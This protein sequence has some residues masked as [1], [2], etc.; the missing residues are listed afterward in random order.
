MTALPFRWN[1]NGRPRLGTLLEGEPASHYPGF[2]DDLR[3]CAAKIVASAPDGDLVFVGRSL[4]SIYDYLTGVLGATSWRGRLVLLI[5][6]MR[7]TS[8]EELAR[9][10]PEALRSGREHLAALGLSPERIERS[11]RPKV[12]VDLVHGGSTF[13]HLIG[14]LEHWA[15][16]S[17]VAVGALRRRVRFLG[18]TVRGKNSP[19]TWRWYQQVEWARRLPRSALRGISIPWHLWTYL[20][21]RQSKITRSHTPEHWGAEDA[22]LPPRRKEALEALRLA[23]RIHERGCERAERHGFAAALAARRPLRDPSLRRLI[24]ELRRG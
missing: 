17:G 10:N 3:D 15:E 11:A 22:S 1:L 14:L 20:G 19:N 9:T 18:I 13:G 12:F 21:D 7:D 5:L 16:E 23:H 8:A 2:L 24:L 4:E 6:S